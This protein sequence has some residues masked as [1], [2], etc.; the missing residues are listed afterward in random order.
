MRLE[1]L[2]QAVAAADPSVVLVAPRVVRR[3]IQEEFRVPSMLVEVPHEKGYCFDR[4]VVFR[5][6]E[7]DELGLELDRQLPPQVILLAR[8]SAEQLESEGR[9]DTLL[10]YWRLPFDI[11]IHLALQ[12]RARESDV[13]LGRERSC[14][15]RSTPRNYC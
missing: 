2:T 1:E 10:T 12:G 14:P 8:P 4:Q 7:Q 13:I 11:P 9:E 15:P 6:V 3:I 5:H